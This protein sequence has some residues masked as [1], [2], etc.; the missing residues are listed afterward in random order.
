[1]DL[2]EDKIFEDD[3][4][5]LHQPTTINRCKFFN[6]SGLNPEHHGAEI[7]GDGSFNEEPTYIF[8]KCVF[9]NAGIKSDSYDEGAALINAPNV[10]F[11]QCRFSHWGKAVLVG[12]GDYEENDKNLRVVFKDCVFENNG[13]RSPYIQYGKAVLDGCLIKNWGDPEYFYLKSHGLRVGSSA[14]CDVVDSIFIQEKFWPGFKNFFS[15]ITN[16]YDPVLIPGNF[17]GAYAETGGRISLKHCYKNSKLVWFSEK[18]KNPMTKQE[19]EEKI[20]YLETNVP[21]L[22]T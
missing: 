6:I 18:N 13:R 15:D 2:I 14:E 7:W 19:A 21:K 8:H 9:D 1:M 11:D 4:I 22:N 3:G 12:N 5:Y 16:Q 20:K 10:V 17:R